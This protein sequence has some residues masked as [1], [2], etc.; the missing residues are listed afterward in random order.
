MTIR[1][2]LL[3]LLL[4]ESLA[5]RRNAQPKDRTLSAVFD[6]LFQYIRSPPPQSGH[7]LLHPQPEDVSY[8]GQTWLVPG[9]GL[10]S[11]CVLHDVGVLV[12]HGK[13]PGVM[14]GKPGNC[15]SALSQPFRLGVDPYQG[16]VTKYLLL[17]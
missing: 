17:F 10:G 9:N 16:H 4:G 11:E 7:F 2:K 8:R 6:S 13:V 3:C 5:T 1:N 14:T 15:Y 12:T